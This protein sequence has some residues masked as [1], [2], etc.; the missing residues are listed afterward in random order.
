MFR[1]QIAFPV[2]VDRLWELL[3][4]PSSV[5]GW[6]G[7]TVDWVLAPGGEIRFGDG[8]DGVRNGRVE[9]VDPP[10]QLRFRWWPETGDTEI[11]EVI[12]HLEAI[13]D[14][15]QLTITEE[16]LRS[17]PGPA[18]DPVPGSAT[19]SIATD[20]ADVL[21]SDPAGRDEPG[22]WSPWDTRLAGVWCSATAPALRVTV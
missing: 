3:T 12:Y 7:S 9:S 22:A 19:D 1:R 16:P 10:H 18:T 5:A 21:S 4:D 15:T 6:F 2:D 11:S 14:G 8:D 17:R 13:E 20:G